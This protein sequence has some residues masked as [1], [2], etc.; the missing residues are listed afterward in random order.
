MYAP[1]NVNTNHF[2]SSRSA[3]TLNT[4]MP[5]EIFKLLF[6][7]QVSLLQTSTDQKFI[8]E[9]AI[10][11]LLLDLKGPDK[12]FYRDLFSKGSKQDHRTP[13]SIRH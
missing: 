9:R 8:I 4:V 10:I 1:L 6:M 12:S 3:H 5:S 11:D 2:H 13:V 7:P